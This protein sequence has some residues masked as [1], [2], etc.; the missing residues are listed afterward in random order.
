[1]QFE[2]LKCIYPVYVDL[3]YE[4]YFTFTVGPVCL[5]GVCSHADVFGLSVRLS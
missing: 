4:I 3:I 1:M 5:C 2:L